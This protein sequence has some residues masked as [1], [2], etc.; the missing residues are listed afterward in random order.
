MESKAV[1]FRGSCDHILQH[2]IDEKPPRSVAVAPE[3]QS[4]V[5]F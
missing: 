5:G 2:C 3:N 1:F 4:E